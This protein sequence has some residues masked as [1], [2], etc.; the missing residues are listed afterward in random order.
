[1]PVV[2]CRVVQLNVK[3]FT[4]LQGQSTV[5]VS[6]LCSARCL[7]PELNVS[8][9]S[10]AGCLRL[11]GNCR[12]SRRPESVSCVFQRGGHKQMAGGTQPHRHAPGN[13]S[14]CPASPALCMCNKFFCAHGMICLIQSSLAMSVAA[15]ETRC[16]LPSISP[17]HLITIC[18]IP[19][20]LEW[21]FAGNAPRL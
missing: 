18:G 1:M 13:A 11:T 14:R 19:C 21:C 15:M 3:R 16:C 7:S 17:P 20:S 5:E 10:A 2:R 8:I 9:H 4:D 6:L 12:D